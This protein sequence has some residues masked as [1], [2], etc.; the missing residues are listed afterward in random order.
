MMDRKSFASVLDEAVGQLEEQVR[1][2]KN[3]KQNL[4]VN[5]GDLEK[6]RDGVG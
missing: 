2:L 4:T 1:S 5:I 6:K 3:Q